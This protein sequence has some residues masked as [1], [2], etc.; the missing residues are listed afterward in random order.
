MG[1]AILKGMLLRPAPA[2]VIFHGVCAMSHQCGQNSAFF[3]NGIRCLIWE[4]TTSG[5]VSVP[6]REQTTQKE[7]CLACNRMNGLPS[8]DIYLLPKP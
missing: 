6:D 5:F 2:I 7:N 3:K 8:L 1:D 4:K